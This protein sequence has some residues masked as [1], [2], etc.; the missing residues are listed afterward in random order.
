MYGRCGAKQ[1]DLGALSFL[2][3]PD[4]PDTV[5]PSL[6][7]NAKANA[8]AGLFW[9]VEDKIFQVRGYDV[10]NITFIRTDHGFVVFDTGAFVSSALAALD[11]IESAL[12]ESVRD[13]VKAVVIS[14]SHADHYGGVAGI[15]D[16]SQVGPSAEGK[17]P[18]IVPAGFAEEVFSENVF[19]GTAMSRRGQ[20]QFGMGLEVGPTGVVSSGLGVPLGSAGR[21]TSYIAP[22]YEVDHDQTL[23]IDGLRIEFQLTPGTEAPA[24]MNCYLP[25]YRAFWAAENCTATLHNVYPIRG[26]KV[27]DASAWSD[28][29]IDALERFGDRSDVVFQSHQWPHWNTPAHPT[30]VRDYLRDTAVAY[31]YVHDRT[32]LWA[33]EGFSA[34][35]IA[36]RISY[37]AALARVGYVRPHY[38]SLEVNARATYQRF[39]GS[40]DGNP[41]DLHPLPETEAAAKFVEYAGGTEAVLDKAAADLARG[42]YQWAAQAAQQV[43]FVDPGCR[44]ARLIAA[45][46]LEQL[47]YRAE[48]SIWRNAYL[49]GA[50]ELRHG[51][52]SPDREGYCGRKGDV[53]DHL[54]ARSALRYLGIVIDGEAAQGE[55]LR[56]RLHVVQGPERQEVAVFLVHLYAGALLVYEGVGTGDAV[57]VRAPRELLTALIHKDLDGVRD[58]VEIDDIAPLERIESYVVDLAGRSAFPLVE[59]G[60]GEV[61]RTGEE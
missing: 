11:L 40:Y 39:L 45:D 42:E 33:N 19:A 17:V 54:D 48:S 27:R 23:V 2:D 43:V 21:T 61:V 60:G 6:W 16:E 31:R 7:L 5:N 15:V 25:Q 46:A 37:P 18:V 44:R 49:T 47:G 13:R 12:G 41:V 38:G 53:I 20:Y 9:V 35:E 1:Y 22:T 26:A 34:N 51:T 55:D 32:L 24:E 30:A 10:A 57:E 29:I 28:Y 8:V 50:H 52:P 36:H 59:R 3:R 14:H 56:L 58:Q 4:V